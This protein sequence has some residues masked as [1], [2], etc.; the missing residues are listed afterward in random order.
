MMEKGNATKFKNKR[1]DEIDIN[2][3]E[4]EDYL[5]EEEEDEKGK[6]SFLTKFI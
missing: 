3:Q 5:L 1:L 2:M 6:L 4:I